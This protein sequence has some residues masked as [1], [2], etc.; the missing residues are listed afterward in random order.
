MNPNPPLKGPTTFRRPSVGAV[1]S[2]AVGAALAGALMTSGIRDAGAV[3]T[4]S[5][6]SPDKANHFAVSAPLGAF[7][8][9]FAGPS[10]SLGMRVLYGTLIGSLPGLAKEFADTRNPNATPSA[11]DMAFNIAGAAFGAMFADRIV[12]RPVAATGSDRVDGMVIQY[13]VDF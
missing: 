6:T 1:R 5:W 13:R 2:V 3:G 10:A 8:A 12:I 11:R 9:S 7:G 4:D